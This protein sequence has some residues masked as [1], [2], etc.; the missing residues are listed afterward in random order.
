MK[1]NPNLWSVKY[2]TKGTRNNPTLLILAASSATAVAKARR[3]VKSQGDK[4]FR[5]ISIKLKGTIDAF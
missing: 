1:P 4:G 2:E 3:F 5:A